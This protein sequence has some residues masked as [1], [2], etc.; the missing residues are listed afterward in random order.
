M[1][2]SLIRLDDSPGLGVVNLL[3]SFQM[4]LRIAKA[5]V[6]TLGKTPAQSSLEETE[7]IY[8]L[9]ESVG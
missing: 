8:T 1:L 5:S 3:V 2:N 9:R 4:D 7:A 6:Q